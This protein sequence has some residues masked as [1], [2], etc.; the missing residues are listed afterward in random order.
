MTL[1]DLD[2]DLVRC[3]L[4]VAETGGFTSAGERLGRTQSAISLKIRRLEEVL[5]RRVFARTSRSLALTTDGELLLGYARRL[6]AL[7]DETLKRFAE[8]EAEGELRVGVAEY[9]VPR[10]LPAVLSAF[11]RAHPRV[12]VE[13]RVGLGASLMEGLDRGALD[14]V[15]A[16][17]DEGVDR[18]RVLMTEALRWVTATDLRLDTATPLP[19][20][21]L[22]SPCIFRARAIEALAG[23]D[24][25]WRVVYTSESVSGVAAAV[26]AGLGIAVL[27]D[28]TVPP[29][30]RVLSEAEGFPALGEVE[31]AVFGEARAPAA[32]AQSFT[33]FVSDRL[34]ALVPSH[35]AA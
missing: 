16:N 8:P 32:L 12:H 14:L 18:G 13:I 9:F 31:L 27:G 6:V 19:L 35:C 2:I 26:T 22:P 33:G 17:R 7:N 24:R 30:V 3:F 10:H 21:T 20:C 34:R 11:A 15:I 25:R 29:G 5:G 28:C 1:P 4:A 23:R